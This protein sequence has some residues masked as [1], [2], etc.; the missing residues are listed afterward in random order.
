[1][2]FRSSWPIWLVLLFTSPLL[3]GP[4]DSDFGH[5]DTGDLPSRGDDWPA[6]EDPRYRALQTLEAGAKLIL[7]LPKAT[8][9]FV[10]INDLLPDA[11]EADFS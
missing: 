3:W 2:R 9:A 5:P 8:P 4:F 10:S 6:S 1:M 7:D 11:R